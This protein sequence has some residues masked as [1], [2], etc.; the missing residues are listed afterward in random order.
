MKIK[1][2]PGYAVDA[3]QEHSNKIELLY[4]ANWDATFKNLRIRS[5]LL[6]ESENESLKEKEE[7]CDSSSSNFN[8]KRLFIQTRESGH[9]TLRVKSKNKPIADWIDFESNTINVVNP[10]YN[11][12]QNNWHSEDFLKNVPTQNSNKSKIQRSH[13]VIVKQPTFSREPQNLKDPEIFNQAI[14]RA[15]T[16]WLNNNSTNNNFAII[17]KRTY[18]SK[19]SKSDNDESCCD[20]AD[21]SI[22]KQEKESYSAKKSPYDKSVATVSKT[23]EESR[24]NTYNRN[25]MHCYETSNATS[26]YVESLQNQSAENKPL[27]SKVLLNPLAQNKNIQINHLDMVSIDKF[28]DL[29]DYDVDGKSSSKSSKSQ[30]KEKRK[31]LSKM[32]YNTISAGS[33]LPKVFLNRP[34]T[35]QRSALDIEN[36]CNENKSDISSNGVSTT[37]ASSS[38]SASSSSNKNCIQ[39]CDK[40]SIPRPRLITP[41]HSFT[42]RKRR[43]GNLTNN[44]KDDSNNKNT[45]GKKSYNIQ[46]CVAISFFIMC[47]ITKYK[48]KRKT[49]VALRIIQMGGERF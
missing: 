49:S 30:K 25:R 1:G 7:H 3:S 6:K 36:L 5:S 21:E 29:K 45:Q 17:S 32:F 18:T 35:Q 44:F 42:T 47:C 38:L 46:T 19:T 48:C 9:Q 34:K 12:T 31:G 27:T 14:K 2:Y 20:D 26:V 22:G 10:L 11:H 33:K 41:V 24:H 28:G 23:Y 37:T 8:Y 13:T 40:F 16:F 4:K 39:S 43:T 15:N